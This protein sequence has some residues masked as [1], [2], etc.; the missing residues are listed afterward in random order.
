V[1]A[2]RGEST[3]AE[4]RGGPWCSSDE[5]FVMKV[6]RRPWLVLELMARALSNSKSI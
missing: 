6:E 4:H 1:E 3:D 2:S 5:A